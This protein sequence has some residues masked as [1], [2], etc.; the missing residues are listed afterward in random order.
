MTNY[1][2]MARIKD[3]LV[4]SS[5]MDK[6][7]NKQTC[8]QIKKEHSTFLVDVEILAHKTIAISSFRM[9]DVYNSPP[10]EIATKGNI[11]IYSITLLN[12]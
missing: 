11:L 6:G 3:N 1:L 7:G 8:R 12:D 5:H 4:L 9:E 10:D 2:M